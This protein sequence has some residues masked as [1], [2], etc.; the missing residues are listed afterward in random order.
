M[1]AVTAEMGRG[2]IPPLYP[3]HQK[4]AWERRTLLMSLVGRSVFDA[5]PP[6]QIMG[7][8]IA[9]AGRCERGRGGRRK[10]RGHAS[11]HRKGSLTCFG[12]FKKVPRGS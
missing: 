5:Y 11:D 2:C 9:V 4:Q 1:T 3:V 8:A 12:D 7:K 10:G 6:L